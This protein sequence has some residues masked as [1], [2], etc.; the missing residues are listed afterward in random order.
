MDLL[1]PMQDPPDYEPLPDH[2]VEAIARGQGRP[3]DEVFYD[4]LVGQDG[5]SSFLAISMNYAERNGDVVLE[6]IEHPMTLVGQ[7]D[8]GAHCL[9]LCDATAP[10]TVLTQWVR[11]RTRGRRLSLERAVYELTRNPARHFGLHDRGELVPGLRADIN[12][13]DFDRLQLGR[14]EFLD[15]L[16]G[17]AH[18]V[19]QRTKGYVATIVSGEIIFDD[20]DDTGAR[21]GRT[22]RHSAKPRE[23]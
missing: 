3:V 4:M 20:G 22:I 11:D 23:H 7:G 18:R 19:V 17:G 12:V 10:T 16:P 14:M 13:I 8:G 5:E 15:D 9:T 1:F 2:S 21:P 6:M